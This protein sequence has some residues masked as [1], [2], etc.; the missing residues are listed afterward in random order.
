MVIAQN[1]GEINQN[2]G[3]FFKGTCNKCGKYDHKAYDCWGNENKGHKNKN[4][5]KP[6]FKRELH[7]CGKKGH[8]VVDCWEKNEDKEYDV[9]NLFVGSKF[10]GEVSDINNEGDV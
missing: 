2:K 6:H 5:G 7:N 8:K 3:E 4:K 9:D 10:C 1:Y